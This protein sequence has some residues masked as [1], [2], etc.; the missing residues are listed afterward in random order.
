MTTITSDLV[1]ADMDTAF[2][3]AA[4][5]TLPEGAR[6]IGRPMWAPTGWALPAA[7]GAS[8]AE[9]S[10]RVVPITR[11]GAMRQ[12]AAAELGTLLAQGLAPVIIAINIGG[13]TTERMIGPDDAPPRLRDITPRGRCRQLI[14]Q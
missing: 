7:L 6:L 5:L 4:D 3:G 14:T 11:D 9:P 2:Y 13:C 12:T 1:V 8:L 10:R